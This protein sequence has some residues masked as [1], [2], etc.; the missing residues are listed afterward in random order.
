MSTDTTRLRDAVERFAETP[1]AGQEPSRTPPP[2]L[3]RTL[4]RRQ[5]RSRSLPALVPGLV[6]AASVV[7][8]VLAVVAG[9]PALLRDGGG[10]PDGTSVAA[11][12]E[13]DALLGA[14]PDVIAEPASTLPVDRS[15][16]VAAALFYG[17]QRGFLP[18]SERADVAALSAE[19]GAWRWL[20][21]PRRGD[22]AVEVDLS[23]TG[24]YI[25]Y[26]S[27]R[28]AEQGIRST[29]LVTRDLVTGRESTWRPPDI[30]LGAMEEGIAWLDATTVL[31]SYSRATGPSTGR[32]SFVV[33]MDAV[34]GEVTPLTTGPLS[35]E[36]IGAG[37]VYP[38]GFAKLGIDQDGESRPGVTVY[39]R[40]GEADGYWLPAGYVASTNGLAVSPDAA[41]LALIPNGARRQ[42]NELIVTPMVPIDEERPAPRVL[43]LPGDPELQY[44]LGWGDEDH[45]IGI[46][47]SGEPGDD[48]IVSIDVRTG[49]TER[50]AEVA[51]LGFQYAD[52]LWT[53]DPAQ[54]S[55]DN[56]PSPT[57]G[58]V[59]PWA[60]L[61]GVV[62]LLLVAIR[63][64]GKHS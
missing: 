22:R 58:D 13:P 31:T 34:S 10:A 17:R 12:P 9:I 43:D 46:G 23:P 56:G 41:T 54:R 64:A 63:G 42:Q 25:A 3:L 45:V 27:P 37:L 47:F 18:W 2:E 36:F 55:A 62:L 49:E 35:Q 59:A 30:P 57:F 39:S 40:A 28:G 29:A 4:R 15:P 38:R 48:P 1:P 44:L 60:L 53:R 11:A 5:R 33:R 21:V 16:G 6:A 7:A 26:W 61:G 24:R 52:L 19:T 8:I 14:I 50:I 32:G 51:P 20:D